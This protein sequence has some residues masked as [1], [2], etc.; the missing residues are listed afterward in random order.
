MTATLY[1]SDVPIADATPNNPI[2]YIKTGVGSYKD[3]KAVTTPPVTPK[4]P[5]AFP[6]LAVL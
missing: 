2:A 5:I 6:I 1:P 3:A 4:I